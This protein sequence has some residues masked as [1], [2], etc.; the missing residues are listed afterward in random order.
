MGLL[1]LTLVIIELTKSLRSLDV[2]M[3]D[4]REAWSRSRQR[5][6]RICRWWSVVSE[7]Q[8]V[9]S[10][11]GDLELAEVEDIPDVPPDHPFESEQSDS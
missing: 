11:L 1:M 2:S 9:S 8:D 3:R 6:R 7:F 4:W 10:I 5:L